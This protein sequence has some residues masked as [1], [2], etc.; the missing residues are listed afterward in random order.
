MY[1]QVELISTKGEVF[2]YW[3]FNDVSTQPKLRSG[4]GLRILEV[5]PFLRVSRVFTS[6]RN[7]ADLPTKS[8]LGTIVEIN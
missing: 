4:H 5:Q 2:V 8:L 3:L 7:L 1:T 6:L